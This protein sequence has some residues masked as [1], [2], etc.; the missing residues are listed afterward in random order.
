VN[1]TSIPRP[2][3]NAL[4]LAAA[5]KANWHGQH[6]SEKADGVC[7]RREFA[8][9]AVWGDSMRD[10][11]LMVWDIDCAFGCDV[12]RL[13]WTERERAL[14]EL[15][16]QLNPKLNWHRCPTGHGAEFIEA[17]I[18]AGGEG[19]VAKPFDAPFG[20][21]L[22][23]VKRTESF[24]L[25]CAER[26]ERRGSIRLAGPG[27]EDYG[28]CPCRAAFDRIRLGD[29]VEIE[30]YGR[31]ASGKLREARFKRIRADIMEAKP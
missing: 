22:W 27:G 31:H 14:T 3:Y 8:G 19:I 30:A 11:R 21:G 7:V 9:C 1:P 2:S 17:I 16:G 12:R 29:V 5:L 13:P 25:V 6:L 24:D 10:G 26:N 20:V 18:Q 4:D 23:K 28:W 15:F